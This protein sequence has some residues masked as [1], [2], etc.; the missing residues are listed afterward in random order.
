MATTWTKSIHRGTSIAAT[1]RDRTE[2]AK[3][4]NKTDGGILIDS[5]ECDPRTVDSEF[6]FSK[7]LYEQKTGRD[8]G[9]HDVIAYHVRMSFKP[10]EV[11]A[12]QSL[13]FGMELARRWTK[14]KHQFIVAAHTNTNSPHAH[15]IF[16]SVNLDCTGKYNDFKRS[17]IALR[18]VSDMIC[19]EHGLSVIEKPGLS[20][21]HN[22]TEYLGAAKPPGVRDQLRDVIDAVL[23]ACKDFDAFL[24]ALVEKGIEVKRGKQ[25]AFRLPGGKKFSRQDTLGDDYSFEAIFERIEGKRVVAPKPKP[26][27]HESAVSEYKPNLLID[28]QAK[29]KEG[30][31]GGYEHWARLFNIKEMSR[32]LL[33][34]KNQGIDGYDELVERTKAVCDDFDGRQEKIRAA[35]GRMKEITELQKH[36]GTYGKTREVYQQYRASG[37]DPGFYETHRADITLHEA[38]KKYFDEHGYGKNKKLPS[39]QSLKQEY[40]ILAAEKKKCYSGWSELK[41]N[42]AALL[43]AKSNA[44]HILGITPDAPERNEHRERQRHYSHDR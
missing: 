27:Y 30:K 29:M 39:M 31:G 4:P 3:D 10:G 42:R 11:T 34:L 7:R 24:A 22:R 5:F 28:I 32:T 12:Q 41:A 8:Q 14:C 25:L 6:L 21:G 43:T 37:R 9:Q 17:A 36:I 26:I 20:K 33:F 40:A 15:I 23:P 19:L 13:E 44:S 38:A 35:E 16:N 18:R 2:Y 1:L